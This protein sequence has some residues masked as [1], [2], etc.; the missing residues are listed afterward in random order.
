MWVRVL[1]KKHANFWDGILCNDPK[2]LDLKGGSRVI[3]PESEV[4]E[5]KPSNFAIRW[6]YHV[7]NYSFP[8]SHPKWDQS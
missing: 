7:Y 5:V 8:A 6:F 1:E 2:Y 3:F 4:T